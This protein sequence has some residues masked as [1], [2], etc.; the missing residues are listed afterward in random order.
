MEYGSGGDRFNISM[1]RDGGLYGSANAKFG[2][3]VTYRVDPT[4]PTA[5]Q[6]IILNEMNKVALLEGTEIPTIEGTDDDP[7]Q[8]RSTQLMGGIL[9]QC[10]DQIEPGVDFEFMVHYEQITP[11]VEGATFR[12]RFESAA[13]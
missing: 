11:D 5:Q 12:P 6:M 8:G 9:Q 2:D 10:P 4:S 13:A 3:E 7:V 1:G